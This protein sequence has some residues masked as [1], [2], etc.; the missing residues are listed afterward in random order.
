MGAGTVMRSVRC[1]I[2]GTER[3]TPAARDTAVTRWIVSYSNP[4]LDT[5]RISVD[6]VSLAVLEANSKAI[7]FTPHPCSSTDC[8]RNGCGYNPYAQGNKAYY[9]P[10]G[11]VD[12][13]KPF[14]VVTQFNT[15]DGTTTG[16]LTSIT[17]K[18]LQNGVLIAPAVTGG[19]ILT[20][21]MCNALDSTAAAFGSLTT[22][23]QALARGSKYNF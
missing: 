11:T 7:D 10:G 23:G 22:M 3:S 6:H 8:D 20:T 14:T 18:Y 1:R 9:G 12:T 15:N 17:R 4:H 13:N 21:E 5:V 16:T 19:D 2:G